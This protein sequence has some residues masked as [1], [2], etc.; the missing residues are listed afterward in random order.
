MTIHDI[1]KEDIFQRIDM[2]EAQVK[3]I[4]ESH[5]SFIRHYHEFVR[6]TVQ[7]LKE[8]NEE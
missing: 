7:T 5:N 3:A 2:L 6:A 8:I 4:Q 1:K